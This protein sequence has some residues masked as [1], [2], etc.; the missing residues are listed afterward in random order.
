MDPGSRRLH[1]LAAG[2][3]VD[4]EPEVAVR[5]AADAGWP[6]CG[7]WFDPATWT[8]R[9]TSEVRRILDDTGTTALD[10]EP[11]IVGSR[12]DPTD[13][14]IEAGAALGARFVLFTSVSDD[15]PVV[16]ERFARAC[17]RAAPAGITV[18]C[19]FLPIFP[20][21][22]L[23][24][25]LSIVR[26]V[27][28]PNAGVLVDNLHLR[29]AGLTPAALDGLDPALLP[30]LQVCDAP[31]E[32]PQDPVALVTEARDGRLWPGEG[33]LPIDELLAAVPG[34]PLSYEVRSST[35]R[36]RFADPRER[37]A[38]GWA[39]VAHLRG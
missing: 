32:A 6:A 38:H 8:A 35:D 9:R 19:E 12:T 7:I 23:D 25:A 4:V 39:A 17:D 30:Y 11:I 13:A 36:E 29:S 22:T 10:I 28:R 20:L 24:R 37:A 15:W 34:V 2:V 5:A 31:L 33:A 26:S 16:T 21:A 3:L 1:S 14:L 18:V 27:E